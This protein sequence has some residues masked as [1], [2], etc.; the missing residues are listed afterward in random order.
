[1]HSRPSLHVV[2]VVVRSYVSSRASPWESIDDRG[3]PLPSRDSC[4]LFLLSSAS[5]RTHSPCHFFRPS[6]T[7][8]SPPSPKTM[9]FSFPILSGIFPGF[10]SLFL[11][12]SHHLFHLYP[13]AMTLSCNNRASLNNA[14]SMSTL[15]LLALA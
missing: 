4:C 5:L 8:N 13:N 1:M 11:R 6:F 2:V 15:L 10:L 3:S 12:L 7:W 14:F 9:S